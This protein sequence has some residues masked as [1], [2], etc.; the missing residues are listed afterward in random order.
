[1]MIDFHTHI[2]PDKIA[3]RTISKLEEVANIKAFT[4]GT[5]DG[6]LHS[7]KEGN[8]DLSVVLPV[9]TKPEQFET[10]NQYAAEI[11]KL[12]GILS[13]G[14]I[15]PRMENYKEGIARIKEL[16]L[17]GIKLHPDYQLTFVDDEAMVRVIEEAVKNDLM[18][19]LHAGIDV[20]Y[21]NPVHCTPKATARMLEQINELDAKIILAHTGGFGLWDEVEEYLVGQNVYF[22]ISYS[23]GFIED[24]QIVRIIK[25]HGADRILFATDC[26]WGGQKETLEHFMSLDLTEEEREAILSENAKRLLGL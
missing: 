7:M 22:D 11:S 8:I 17:K 26:P 19:T 16:G 6:L 13:F 12:D 18:V 3:E 20:G 14:G 21:P 10:I 4:N 2:F 24:E 5:L 25:N 1:M 23:F 15:H 9:V